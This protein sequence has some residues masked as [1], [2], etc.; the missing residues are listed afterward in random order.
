MGSIKDINI[1]LEELEREKKK[2]FEE[3]LKFIDFWTEYIK[4]HSDK[5]WSKQQNKFINSQCS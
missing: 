5:E 3:R 4:K 1:D 2:N